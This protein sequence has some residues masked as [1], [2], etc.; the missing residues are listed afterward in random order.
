MNPRNSLPLNGY[1]LNYRVFPSAPALDAKVVG[2]SELMAET[3]LEDHAHDIL[4]PDYLQFL[5]TLASL[6]A[7]G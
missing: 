5:S 4:I 3:L 7:G 2:R 1:S 6:V